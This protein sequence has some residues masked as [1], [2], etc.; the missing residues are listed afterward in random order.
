VA[1]WG[2]PGLPISSP[3][4]GTITIPP[5]GLT[6]AEYDALSGIQAGNPVGGPH[7]QAIIDRL[8]QAGVYKPGGTS[9]PAPG[10]SP[11]TATTIPGGGTQVT[12]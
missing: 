6:Q 4:G 2:Q 3:G 9:Q 5:T 8:I 10:G 1:N 12:L 7:A 11:A